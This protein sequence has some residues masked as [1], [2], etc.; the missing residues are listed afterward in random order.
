MVIAALRR[1]MIRLTSLF[2][3]LICLSHSGASSDIRSVH[4][5]AVWQ[6]PNLEDSIRFHA[7]DEFYA[8][9]NQANPDTT[10]HFLAYH[11]L[12]A[13]EKG[14][15]SE[16]VSALNKKANILRLQRHYELALK[17]YNQALNAAIPLNKP[18]LN[19]DITGNIAN[20]FVYKSDYTN[21][22]RYFYES[23]DVYERYH[24]E[25]GIVRSR[26]SIGNIF[27]IMRNYDLALEYYN[28]VLSIVSSK[29]KNDRTLGILYCNMGLA[30]YH[31]QNYHQARDFYLKG[32]ANYEEHNNLFF[33]AEGSCDLARIYLKLND[34]KN[35]GKQADI[36]INLNSR[37]SNPEGLLEAKIVKAQI[38]YLTNPALSCKMAEPLLKEVQLYENKEI[39]KDLY[40]LMYQCYKQNGQGS[41]A[42]FMHENYARVSDSINQEIYQYKI[43]EEAIHRDHEVRINKMLAQN[44]Q[45]EDAAKINQLRLLLIIGLASVLIVSISAWM[46]ILFRRKSKAKLHDLLTEIDLLKKTTQ[47]ELLVHKHIPSLD[48]LKIEEAISRRLN[49]TDWL[50]LNILFNDP[51]ASNKT[52]ADR[53]NLSVDGIGSSLRR[54]Y[55]F[56]EIGDSKYKKISLITMAIKHSSR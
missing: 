49:E 34:Y 33:A 46:F 40:F 53:A 27:L 56:F 12:L 52:I 48:R 38:A 14:N 10:L 25:P 37:L 5:K 50:V 18:L 42:L 44:R 55:E 23:L 20:V 11:Y 43:L 45:K 6:N 41:K 21:A 2:F 30:Y 22:S 51:V 13:Q 39:K 24:F 16:Q 32:I 3:G 28:T 29:N 8:L 54:M 36:S 35:A 7:H 1:R 19:A 15:V 4:L 31:L 26:T 17:T 9:N 47:N